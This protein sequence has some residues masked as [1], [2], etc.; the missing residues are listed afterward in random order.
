[1]TVTNFIYKGFT[2]T[3]TDQSSVVFVDSADQDHTAQ[4]MQSDL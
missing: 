3:V 1:M 2:T 4:K